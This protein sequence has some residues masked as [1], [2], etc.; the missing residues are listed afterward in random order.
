MLVSLKPFR[1]Y[2]LVKKYAQ[3]EDKYVLVIDNTNWFNL[4]SA[5]QT[6]VKDYH[7]EIP[8]DE[9]GEIFSNRITCYA[10]DTQSI[11]T[12]TAHTWLPKNTDLADKD[13]FIECYVITPSGGIPYTNDDVE[14]PNPDPG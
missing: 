3:V 10:F 14:N 4:D 11:A 8:T 12:D 13:F 6:Q 1:L 9:V 7:T 2:E 5:K